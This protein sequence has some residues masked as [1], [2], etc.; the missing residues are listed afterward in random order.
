MNDFAPPHVY[1]PYDFDIRRNPRGYWV[2]RDRN[3]LVGGIFL[4]QKDAI[5]FALFE[6]GGDSAHVHVRA[7]RRPAPRHHAD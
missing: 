7:A 6:T 3:G 1:P 4:T 2:A 5:R